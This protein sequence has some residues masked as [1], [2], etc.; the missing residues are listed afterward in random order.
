MRRIVKQEEQVV[1]SGAEPSDR[2]VQWHIVSFE[3]REQAAMAIP[4]LDIRDNA[5]DDGLT[6][7]L[8]KTTDTGWLAKVDLVQNLAFDLTKLD[9]V[10]CSLEQ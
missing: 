2:V 7:E 5:P 9:Y 6:V 3:W 4:I 10:T 8:G 1:V